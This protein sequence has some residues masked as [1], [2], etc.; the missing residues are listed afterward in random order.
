MHWE[1]S[2]CTSHFLECRSVHLWW[3]F[4]GHNHLKNLI[5]STHLRVYRMFT[6]SV[7]G[8]CNWSGRWMEHWARFSCIATNKTEQ[9]CHSCIF[10][11]YRIAVK[12]Q[13][14]KRHMLTHS[15]FYLMLALFPTDFFL[16][17]SFLNFTNSF[18]LK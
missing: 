8:V 11:L 9:T 16:L 7:H 10:L 3:M 15:M 18:F 14:I 1:S 5:Y 2:P 6:Y 13:I 17:S 12:T 4:I